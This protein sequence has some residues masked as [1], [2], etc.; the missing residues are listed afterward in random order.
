MSD[1]TSIFDNNQ[2]QPT[3]AN[4]NNGGTGTPPN[5]NQSNPLA[6]LL[7]SIK[8]DRGEPKY[9]SVE[10]ALNALKHSQDYIPQLSDKLKQQELELAEAKA[11]AAKISQ[12]E[13]T[14]KSLTQN[15]NNQQSSPPAPAGL[16]AEDVA[17]LVSQ[18]L[19]KQQQADLAKANIGT[20]VSAVTKAFGDKSEEVFYGKAKELGMSVEDI[21]ALASRTP[22]AAL[23]LLGLD[24]VKTTPTSNT[25]SV[26]T[27]AFQ[28]TQ[29]TFVGKNAKPTL[30]GATSADLK[31]EAVNSRRMV[32]ELHNQG[33]TVHDLTD[34][35]VYFKHFK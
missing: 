1:P 20:V 16:S 29:E 19:T 25:N 13:D 2:N 30:I 5:G 24:G 7:G 23:K 11:A 9:K 33:L 12:L 21:N 26:N 22:T 27:S 10:D 6:D 14:L 17:T 31:E 32:D 3:Q 4:Q 34:P 35:K 15:A 18:T 8:N 28:P